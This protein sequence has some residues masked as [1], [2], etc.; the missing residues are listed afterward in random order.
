MVVA[1]DGEEGGGEFLFNGLVFQVCKIRDV[2][3]DGAGA[4]M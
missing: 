2:E 1:R 3:T 4:T